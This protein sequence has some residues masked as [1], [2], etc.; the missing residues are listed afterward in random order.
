LEKFFGK[1]KHQE[2]RQWWVYFHVSF[3]GITLESDWMNCCGRILKVVSL[4]CSRP[5]FTYWVTIVELILYIVAVSFYGIAPIGTG[6]TEITGEVLM[7]SLAIEQVSYFEY[8]NLWIGPTQ[9][10]SFKHLYQH[11]FSCCHHF[12]G[13]FNSHG[14]QVLALHA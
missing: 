2:R 6:R 8:D 7:A 5:Y 11:I 3:L 14:S 1:A 9:V 10:N 12:V 4:T 13:R